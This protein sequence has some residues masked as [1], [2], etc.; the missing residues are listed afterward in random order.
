MSD[1]TKHY[2]PICIRKHI[3]GITADLYVC[4]VRL[5]SFEKAQSFLSTVNS[6]PLYI[7]AVFADIH[8]GNCT[9]NR[10]TMGET[11]W[12]MTYS[13]VFGKILFASAIVNW[14]LI[15]EAEF[16]FAENCILSDVGCSSWLKREYENKYSPKCKA[17]QNLGINPGNIT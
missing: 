11:K 17:V 2:F 5:E 3:R 6:R 1:L 10:P 8:S 13:D 12:W 4:A 15:V 9:Q 16:F 14:L 7:P